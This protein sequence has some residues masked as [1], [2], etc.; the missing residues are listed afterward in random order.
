MSSSLTEEQ[1]TRLRDAMISEYRAMSPQLNDLELQRSAGT[2]EYLESEE[3]RLQISE[4]SNLR[5]LAAA[6]AYLTVNQ[7]A[8][9]EETLRSETNSAREKLEARRARHGSFLQGPDPPKTQ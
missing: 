5:I 4:A 6:Q 8:T 7:L 2:L 3:K 9:L 1:S